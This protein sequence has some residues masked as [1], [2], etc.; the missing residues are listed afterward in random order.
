MDDRHVVVVGGGIGGLTAALLLARAGARV[1]LF[2]AQPAARTVGAGML[3]QPNGLAVLYGL[4]LDERLLRRG[5]RLERLRVA[6]PAGVPN[7]DVPVPRFAEG[8][9]R[10][11]TPAGSAT[12]SRSIRAPRRRSRSSRSRP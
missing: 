10:I 9:S 8:T 3:L 12:R 7:L 6:D 2:E 1:T 5:A 11:G 4:D